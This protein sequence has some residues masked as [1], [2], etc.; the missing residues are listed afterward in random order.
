M[1]E[2]TSLWPDGKRSAFI[3]TVSFE[4]EL[5][6]LAAAPDAVDRAKSLSVGQYGATRGVDRLLAELDRTG[7][8]A[9]WF[10]P[11]RNAEAY[12]RQVEAIAA[13]G[14]ELGNMGWALEDFSNL[15]AEGQLEAIR[16]GQSAF[17]SLLGVQP[18]GFRAGRGSY[19][20][21]LPLA[22]LDEG[23]TWSSSW[24]GDDLPH[25]HAGRAAELVEIPRHHELDDFPYFVFNLDPPIPKGSPRIASSRE[26]LSNWLIEFEAYR[27]EGLC[28]VL[29]VHPELIATPGRIGLL[30]E[31]LDHVLSCDDVWIATCGD[32]ASWWRGYGQSNAPG[33]PAEIFHALTTATTGKGA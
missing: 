19:A 27:A 23:F 11:G 20:H 9:T 3:L 4:A 14:H 15:G 16:R 32:V 21:G 7:I 1:S 2:Q 28:F 18:T 12:P 5:A 17:E 8:R 22:L 33:H 26:V 24:H 6:V 31:F 30:R 25:F 13:E 10:I 29:T